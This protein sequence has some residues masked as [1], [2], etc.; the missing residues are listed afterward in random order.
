MQ[1]DFFILQGLGS[2]NENGKK[3]NVNTLRGQGA[4]GCEKRVGKWRRCGATSHFFEIPRPITKYP[5]IEPRIPMPDSK[6][7]L[8]LLAAAAQSRDDTYGCLGVSAWLCTEM[9]QCK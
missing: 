4:G 9:V 2:F 7:L 3:P 6:A 8:A 5:K 1:W